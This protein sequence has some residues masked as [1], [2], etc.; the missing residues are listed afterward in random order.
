MADLAL[1][2]VEPVPRR[3][4]SR[5]TVDPTRP[6]AFFVEKERTA[7]GFVEAMATL[8]LTNKECP[9]RCVFC[10]LWKNTL[11]YRLPPGAM[12]GQ[13]RWALG[14]MPWTPHVKLYN[15]GNFFDE[16]AVPRD[17]RRAIAAL[18]G[19]RRTVVVEC[20]PRLVDRRCVEFA[21]LLSGRLEVAMGLETI[22]PEVLPRL[23]KGMTLADFERACAYLCEHDIGVRA[24]ILLPAPFQTVEQGVRWARGSV[25]FAFDRGVECCSL[26]PLRS[27]PTVATLSAMEEVLDHGVHLRRGRVFMDL[28]DIERFVHCRRCGAA[29][30]DRLR[31]MNLEQ[32]ILPRVRCECGT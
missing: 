16:Q 23:A 21:G 17:D 8:F 25:E 14:Q 13:V 11:S 31:R 24:F 28:W 5:N 12:V 27:D 6:Y 3:P 30:A 18:L 22:D 1:V 15:S 29:R 9:F 20:H 26:I 4:G 10:D 7:T 19:D 32:T 2:G